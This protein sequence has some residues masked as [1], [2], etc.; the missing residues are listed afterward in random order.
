[1]NM[2]PETT[3]EKNGV[4]LTKYYDETEYSLPSIV[5]SFSSNRS[6]P[7]SVR[8]VEP[9][10]DDLDPAHIG[11]PKGE[12]REDWTL[13]ETDL[14]L[15][16]TIEPAEEYETLYALRPEQ[17]Y[18][19][20]AVVVEPDVFEV[21]AIESITDLS[22][23]F[24]RSAG[25]SDEAENG[26]EEQSVATMNTVIETEADSAPLKEIAIDQP[27]SGGTG[28]QEQNDASLVDQLA[29][30]LEQGAGSAESRA[31]LQEELELAGESSST[32]ARIRQL[33]A[34]LSDFR[35]YKNALKEFLDENGSA[36][37]L[38]DEFEARMDSFDEELTSL[39]SD[40]REQDDAIDTVRQEN[41]QIQSDLHSINSEIESLT[42][43]VDGLRDE[44]SSLDD[45]VPDHD[46][47][48]Q[49]SDIEAEVTE[50]S[51][52]MNNLKS[53]FGQE[54]D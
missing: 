36:Q 18:D 50:L 45:R 31:L 1:M 48:E 26:V 20:D 42:E 37:E 8:V 6:E 27:A 40:L 54:S 12:A 24:P 47:G 4:E 39:E 53:V 35:A 25:S 30:E 9:I 28:M 3:H 2:N 51:E 5:Y 32:D 52:F 44:L 43:S 14:V 23:N 10:A 17:S 29:T 21:S 13:R 38:I 19:P 22:G 49:M 11:F 16:C 34:D 15:E 46:V 41:E 7:V 33:Q